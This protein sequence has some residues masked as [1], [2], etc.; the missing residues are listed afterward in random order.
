MPLRI[1]AP[2]YCFVS[3]FLMSTTLCLR[4][5]VSESNTPNWPQ[6]RGPNALGVAT[7]GHYPTKFGPDHYMLW[8]TEVPSGVSSPC[9]W[10]NYI[11]LTY[12]D[13]DMQ[14]LGTL[15]IDRASGRV[16][17]RRDARFEQLEKVRDVSSPANSTPATDGQRVYV[18]FASCGLFCYDF[19]GHKLWSKEMPLAEILFGNGASPIVADG[20]VILN[21]DEPPNLTL[22]AGEWKQ[23]GTNSRVLAVRCEDGKTVWK[24]PRKANDRRYATPSV[25]KQDNNSQVLL[26]GAGRLD[27]YDV[28]TGK[29]IWCWWS[30]SSASFLPALRSRRRNPRARRAAAHQDTS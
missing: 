15:C 22:E 14:K 12:F 28:S 23:A 27:A 17:W 19:E 13:K 3:L 20:K 24:T 7:H 26:C 9:I 1:D 4:A 16:L 29:A 25:W 11:F 21:L 18:Y 8:K 10:G 30:P 6:F 5:E 2:L